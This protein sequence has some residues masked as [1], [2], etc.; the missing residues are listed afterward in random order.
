MDMKWK[1]LRNKGN[2][3]GVKTEYDENGAF[4]WLELETDILDDRIEWNIYFRNADGVKDLY[5][6]NNNYNTTELE[7]AVDDII[8]DIEEVYARVEDENKAIETL[9]MLD[10]S[11]D[12]ARNEIDNDNSINET[13][14][15]ELSTNKDLAEELRSKLELDTNISA[16]LRFSIRRA[17]LIQDIWK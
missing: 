7:D 6:H 8:A 1:I 14:L 11:I 15:E 4:W 2:V 16:K 5:L 13:T 3:N 9:E 10:N 12:Q 17:K